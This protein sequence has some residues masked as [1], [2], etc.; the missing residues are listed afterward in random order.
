MNEDLLDRRSF[1]SGAVAATVGISAPIAIQMVDDSD[2]KQ[3]TD[4]KQDE[5]DKGGDASTGKEPVI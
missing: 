1:I 5:D 4:T 3:N 2:P